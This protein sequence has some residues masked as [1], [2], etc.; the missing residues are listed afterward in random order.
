[1]NKILFVDDEKLITNSLERGLRKL[2]YQLIFSNTG[3][4]ALKILENE[5]IDVIVS[6]M[7]MPEINGL[8]LLKEVERLYPRIVKI[9]LSGYAQLPQ[10]IATINQV[11]IFKYIAKPFDIKN[12]LIVILDDAVAYSEFRKE[13]EFKKKSLETKNKTYQNIF[14]NYDSKVDAISYRFALLKL[15]NDEIFNELKSSLMNLDYEK[16]DIHEYKNLL[17]SFD[18]FSKRII[19]DSNKHINVIQPKKILDDIMITLDKMNYTCD[20]ESGIDNSIED[21]Y[22]GESGHIRAIVIGIIESLVNDDLKGTIKMVFAKANNF[23]LFLIEGESELFVISE[24]DRVLLLYGRII[25]S[26]GG[27]FESRKLGENRIFSI[28]IKL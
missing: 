17:S 19:D 18:L 10:L 8:E 15:I 3:K 5:D 14:K 12:E 20:F 27:N 9:I 26:L 11:N 2:P 23:L 4:E 1:M 24:S 25:S 7:K 6:D 21:T 28:S 16:K 22:A 13:Q